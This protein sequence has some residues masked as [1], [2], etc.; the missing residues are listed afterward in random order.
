MLLPMAFSE[1][2]RLV[3]K[4]FSV[5]KIL[6]AHEVAKNETYYPRCGGA[7]GHFDRD[8]VARF[9]FN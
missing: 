5:S 1:A 6:A 2:S 7:S 4:Q 8:S 3:L 9:E